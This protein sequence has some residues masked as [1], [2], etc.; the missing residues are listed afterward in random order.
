MPARSRCA[1]TMS[2]SDHVSNVWYERLAG[3]QTLRGRIGRFHGVLASQLRPGMRCGTQKRGRHTDRRREERETHNSGQSGKHHLAIQLFLES[4]GQLYLDAASRISSIPVTL[5]N[6]RF[7]K[8]GPGQIAH[9]CAAIAF[10]SCAI[11]CHMS[12][13]C[14]YITGSLNNQLTNG[15]RPCARVRAVLRSAYGQ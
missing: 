2:A 11:C 6:G 9:E 5:L 7:V 12:D 1:S 8:T 14:Q 13:S 3:V 15:L 10:D 4:C